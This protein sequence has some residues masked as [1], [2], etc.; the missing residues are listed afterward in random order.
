[1]A[2]SV[3]SIDDVKA[4]LERRVLVLYAGAM[5]ETLPPSHVPAKGVDR[6]RAIEIIRG[7][8][9]A[10][11][12]HAKARE[13]IHLL[14]S[15]LHPGVY[16]AD[17]INEQLKALDERL[18]GR[19]LELVE[20]YEQTIVGVACGLTQ[21]LEMQPG[22]TYSTAYTKEILDGLPGLKALPLLQP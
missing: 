9:G 7:S 20:K 1:M 22:G 14:R 10:E 3:T 16:D 5:A 19:T 18:W 6:D 11:Q 4:Y 8:L 13:A 12:D 2:E 15:I 21:H 17:L